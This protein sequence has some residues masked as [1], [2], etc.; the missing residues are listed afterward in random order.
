[1]RSVGRRAG[2]YFCTAISLALPI[3]AADAAEYPVLAPQGFERQ[4]GQPATETVNFTLPH[5]R[6]SPYTLRVYNGGLEDHDLTGELVSSSV[7]SL[8]GSQ[9]FGPSDFNQ[10][11]TRAEATVELS[12]QNSLQV[13][14]NG[15]PGGVISLLIVGT[16]DLPPTIEAELTPLANEHG[17]HS[18][19]VEVSF[20]CEDTISGIKTC[21]DPIVVSTQGENQVVTGTAEDYAGNTAK[22]SVEINLDSN[23]PLISGSIEVPS[24][25][26][27]WHREDVNVLFTCDDALSGIMTCTG[28][29]A[30]SAEGAAQRV[31]G[32][33]RD[34]AGNIGTTDVIV[35]LDKTAPAI[36]AI[37][38]IPANAGGWHKSSVKV[39]FDCRDELSGIAKCSQ[40]T[41]LSEEGLNQTAEGLTAD[42]AGNQAATTA[43]VNLDM[44]APVIE[45]SLSAEANA[46][47][48]HNSDFNASFTCTDALSG[49][50]Q[51]PESTQISEEGAELNVPV[52][53]VDLA[54]NVAQA[55]I[56]YSLDKTLP[57]II[58]TPTPAANAQGWHKTDVQVT[59]ACEDALS[60]IASCS[61]A[62]SFTAEGANQADTGIA[63]DVAGNSQSSGLIFNIDKT[64][65]T[66]AANLS[67]QA[68]ENGWHNSPVSIS[69]TCSDSLSGMADCPAD[70]QV[71]ADGADQTIAA[72]A[73]DV[74]G[75]EASQTVIINL[76]TT[77]PLVA[78]DSPAGGSTSSTR[79]PELRI[80]ISDALA[81]LP[82]TLAITANGNPVQ[83]NCA[84]DSGIASCT[85]S[86]DVP[87][88]EVVLQASVLDAAGNMG[89]ASVQITLAIDSDGDGISDPLDQC[90]GTP[91]G[92]TADV[93][94][95]SPS[96]L[97]LD[98]DGVPNGTDQCPNTP[99]GTVVA[100][101]GCDDSQ[102]DT[103]GDGVIDT[104][105]RF[106]EDASEHADLDN[107][108]IGDNSDP[109]RDG[110]GVDN[111]QD[112]FP[113]D[114]KESGDLDE[115]G[116]GDNADPDRDGDGVAN[117][118]DAFPDDP[119]RSTLPLI[120]IDSPKTLT[121]V[122]ISPV[123][124]SGRV[125]PTAVSVTLNDM[126]VDFA[127]GVYSGEVTLEEGHNTVAARMVDAEGIVSTA[128][129][130][131]S[132]DLTPPYV[133]VES[134][135]DGQTVHTA[136]I[137]VSGLI[138]DIVRGTIEAD[139]A[140]V[141]INGLDA[142]ISNRSYL[143]EN[144]P[145]TEGSNV[146]EV[147]GI[148]QVG[149]TEVRRITVVY[150]RPVGKRLEL[151]SGQNQSAAINTQ[152]PEPLVVRV[153]DDA[154]NPVANKNVVFRITQGSGVLAVGDPLEG[155][156]FLAKTNENGLASTTFRVGQRAGIGNQKVRARVVG[157]EDEIVFYASA[158]GN[159]GN[160]LSAN[161]GNNQ[162]GSVHQPLPAPFVVAVTDEGANTVNGARVEFKVAQGGGRFQN[163]LATYQ[164]QTDSDGRASAHL[165]LGGITG[166]DKQR[167]TATL[168]D[169]PV[170]DG[171]M[172]TITAGFT[173]SG[174][175]PADPALTT[176]TGTVLDNQ[177]TPLPSVTVRVDGTTRQALT[178]DQ[179][180]FEITEAPVGPVHL[181]VDASTTTAEGE[182]P[183]LAYDLV[184]VSGAKNPLPAPVYM[185]KLNT[186][187]AVW[188]GPTDVEVVL[189]DVPGFKLEIPAGSV[190]FP[191][192]S[193]EGYVS[194][195]VVNSS[196]VPMP[197]PNGMQPQFIVTIQPTGAMFDPPARLSLPNVDA[198]PPGAQIE[199][200]SYDHDLEEFV[201]IGLGT[202]S[203]DGTVVRSNPGVGV[204]KAGWHCGAQPGGSGCCSGP[205]E[206][207][208]YCSK[209]NPG[210]DAG[211]SI[212]ESKPLKS[213]DQVRGNCSLETCGGGEPD[214]S[215]RP[216]DTD[217]A[218]CKRPSCTDPSGF[219]TA[220]DQLAEDTDLND[221][222]KPS[223]DDPRGYVE[224]SSQRA[225]DVEYDC[226][227]PICRN[228]FP[229]DEADD[230]DISPEDAKC[231]IC[232][233]KSLENKPDSPPASPAGPTP[234]P[235][236]TFGGVTSPATGSWGA[237]TGFGYNFS[238]SCAAI[239]SSG[240]ERHR[241]EGDITPS[242]SWVVRVRT[243]VELPG[244]ALSARTAA[245]ISRTEVHELKH[246]NFLM[247]VINGNK[248]AIGRVFDSSSE[249][250]TAVSDLQANLQS[251]WATMVSRQVAHTDF[252]GEAQY[253][254]TCS[255]G[256]T[257]E[258]PSGSVYP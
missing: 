184:T 83:S 124:V 114:P 135:E 214:D 20:I 26:A 236:V 35:S 73:T 125:D 235:T 88:G 209:P 113:T 16:D 63:V 47:G 40:P 80:A 175:I 173:A 128:S 87:T 251:E 164:T 145:L 165:T 12:T 72:A 61:E 91:A 18:G 129:I 193:K 252:S 43:T 230:S 172:Q 219:E 105:D 225:E 247:S 181:V 78:F 123:T 177:D 231:K 11:V 162:R 102:R 207:D 38:D 228:A 256:V 161:S 168:L 257:I 159:I 7:I 106:P 98:G 255:G 143:V 186:E 45:S 147:M 14:L 24:N 169:A 210:C 199:M 151:V 243:E 111:D 238:V 150:K 75:N 218:D 110:D 127:D 22:I 204:V 48:W 15:K 233:D 6:G 82:S 246:A 208:D 176:I 197:P 95:C 112:V 133:T 30:V 76:D 23:A 249:C 19:N 90:P 101:D 180:Q 58:A 99:V 200:F 188:A 140:S 213:E 234:T 107:D 116:V 79:R 178:N 222:R 49:I 120:T 244:C 185:V 94:G 62:Q 227:K 155:R 92:E 223:C 152:L 132:V 242:A 27:G 248:S 53:A 4:S 148:D 108:G 232:N 241:V 253:T 25:A 226:K 196:K 206:C 37:F 109:D 77:P 100:E 153:L 33:A 115:D 220:P 142:Q 191:D 250:N 51:C 156:G 74:A 65:P 203:E 194:A 190:T 237:N 163:G 211:C 71:S 3:A 141:T 56:S 70:R 21:P 68:N 103:D 212:D 85:L 240:E 144:V 42:L 52:N 66:L 57:L 9:I 130:S 34:Y 254:L 36:E 183:T 10:Q 239:C 195:T 2:F 160:K 171:A 29:T 216:E 86:E 189:P 31:A 5:L 134:H 201:A 89:T 28:T 179:G 118:S 137:S 221:C 81:L 32:E 198:H 258:I 146:I 166:L 67:S 39:S 93:N 8:N 41:T 55:N 157:Y 121:T 117:E 245:N 170:V 44:T 215:D 104:E 224:D 60:G 154:G 1:V 229:E 119:S 50:A 182:Y 217:L 96:Q 17:W 149:N 97:D 46:A 167:V 202:V 64:P 138:N 192:G 13:T 54:D 205:E 69:Y 136:S 84:F 126:P 131:I 139:Q 187:N 59:Y 174:F 122:G 158:T